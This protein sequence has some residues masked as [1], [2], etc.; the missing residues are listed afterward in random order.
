MASMVQPGSG[1]DRGPLSSP[2]YDQRMN[3]LTRA[4]LL[5]GVASAAALT[6]ATVAPWYYQPRTLTR[7]MQKR[8]GYGALFEVDTHQPLFALTFDDGPHP[9]YTDAVLDTLAAYDAKATFFCM[10]QQIE[11]HP[12]TFARIVAE[13][14][15]A[16][17]HFWDGRLGVALTGQETVDSLERTEALLDGA[18][19]SRLVRPASGFVR[20][21]QRRLLN[22]RGYHIVIGSAYT[23]DPTNP[24]VAYM[25][26]ALKQM[27]EPGRIVI[28]HDGRKHR[29]RT[30]DVLPDVLEEASRLGLR[31]VSVTELVEA[32]HT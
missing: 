23:S 27:L 4:A 8:W 31:A 6:A 10:G 26:W 18:N 15:E 22:E 30:V 12:A 14:H 29:Q 11:R 13:G 21:E 2:V 28:L 1:S 7:A 19:P 3:S 24:P 25:K 32:A 5:T 16:A 20:P 9:P 17:N